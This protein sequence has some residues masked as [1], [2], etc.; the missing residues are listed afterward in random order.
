MV[1]QD[2]FVLQSAPGF[3]TSTGTCPSYVVDQAFNNIDN[4]T[5]GN[6]YTSDQFVNATGGDF[7]LRPDSDVYKDMPDFVR[8]PYMAIGPRAPP[9]P[10][11]V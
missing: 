4:A 9:P 3:P 1:R 6:F 11:P 2:P 5:I 10:P 8:V 7:T